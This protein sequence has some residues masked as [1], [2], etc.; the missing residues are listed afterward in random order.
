V[1]L[2]EVSVPQDGLGRFEKNS[3]KP[4]STVEPVGVLLNVMVTVAVDA[5]LVM[6]CQIA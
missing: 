2:F 5:A 4:V 6:P 3:W 1:V